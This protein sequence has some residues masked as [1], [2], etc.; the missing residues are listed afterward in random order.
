MRYSLSLSVHSDW[1]DTHSYPE[2]YPSPF[3]FDPQKPMLILGEMD[4]SFALDIASN[5][6]GDHIIATA[7]Y[8]EDGPQAMTRRTR[9]NIEMFKKLGGRG[10]AFRVDATRLSETLDFVGSMK[11][12]KILFGF[13]RSAS[14]PDSVKH[15][16]EFMQM[17]FRSVA[18]FLSHR[19]QFQLFLH[20]KLSQS[21]LSLSISI[22]F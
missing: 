19:G 18:P 10:V 1:N 17:V 13:P 4:F 22:C 8:P 9:S 6:G 2:L 7:Y 16:I 15:N 21:A 14:H 3:R 5:I 20:I 12:D 11:F